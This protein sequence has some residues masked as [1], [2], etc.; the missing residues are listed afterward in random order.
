MKAELNL[1]PKPE[2]GRPLDI[3]PLPICIPYRNDYYPAANNRKSSRSQWHCNIEQLSVDPSNCI[4]ANVNRNCGATHRPESVIVCVC[5]WLLASDSSVKRE[6]TRS[7]VWQDL[8]L[9]NHDLPLPFG[10][11]VHLIMIRFRKCS[12]NGPVWWKFD[13]ISRRPGVCC[14]QIKPQNHHY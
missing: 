1:T 4:P 13:N 6:A 9:S 5:V 10:R 14:T 2:S 7:A 12:T 3:V 8:F 11:I